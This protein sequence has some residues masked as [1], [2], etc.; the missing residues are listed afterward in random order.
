MHQFAFGDGDDDLYINPSD[1]DKKTT[2]LEERT[3][4]D[5]DD[6]QSGFYRRGACG[7]A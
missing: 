2:Y 3:G 7:C 1:A 4:N 6:Q 5:A